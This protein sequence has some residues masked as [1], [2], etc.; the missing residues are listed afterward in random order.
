MKNKK[1]VI[2]FILISVFTIQIIAKI[3]FNFTGYYKSFMSFM[4]LPEEICKLSDDLNK[5]LGA[6]NNNLQLKT[7]INFNENLD[8]EIAYNFMPTVQSSVLFSSSVFPNSMEENSYRLSDFDKLL[9]PNEVEKNTNFGIYQNLDRFF[10]T[11]QTDFADIFIGRQP[12]AWGSARIINPTD[13]LSPF[14]FNE[15]D[16]EERRGVDA[17]RIRV[18]VGDM[19]ELDL[20]YVAG[21]NGGVKNDAFFLRG[22]TEIGDYGVSLLLIKSFQNLL[23]GADI[24]G[25]VGGAGFWIEGAYTFSSLFENSD[26]T[27]N[28]NYFRLSAGLEYKFSDKFYAFCEYH[29]NSLGENLPENYLINNRRN[30]FKEGA[31]YLF[32]KHYMSFAFG[33]NISPLLPLN[34]LIIYNINDKS[35]ILSPTLE[36]NISQNIYIAFGGYFAFGKRAEINLKLL[37]NNPIRTKSEFGFSPSIL[38]SSFRIYF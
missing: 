23:I 27:I 35:F 34:G 13:I 29:F 28:E 30:E 22:K 26:N 20:G 32:G 14:T 18:P 11:V 38:Y 1:A 37:P 10:L 33:Y 16:K 25:A 4:I 8:F 6:V 17:I 7:V 9:Y 19:G 2:F 24:T 12:I 3:K 15:L 5:N 21:D 31:I 36:Y